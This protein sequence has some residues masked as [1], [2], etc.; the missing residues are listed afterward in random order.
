MSVKLQ[1]FNYSIRDILTYSDSSL[2]TD[3][4]IIA[5]DQAKFNFTYLIFMSEID[6]HGLSIITVEF[7][8]ALDTFVH[9]QTR[10]D[11]YLLPLKFMHT[12][13]RFANNEKVS[14]FISSGIF[15][16]DMHAR[17]ITNANTL[18][19]RMVVTDRNV[20]SLDFYRKMRNE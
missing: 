20:V 5:H 9:T 17:M 1:G 14:N 16:Q 8:K 11:L 7:A 15:P 6:E 4:R 2:P 3:V 13:G 18:Q 10:N 19:A 12:W